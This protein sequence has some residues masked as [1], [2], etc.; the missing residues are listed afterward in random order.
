M[1]TNIII[2]HNNII[3]LY[4]LQFEPVTYIVMLVIQREDFMNI[5]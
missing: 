2:E 1:M 5:F 3:L 4:S